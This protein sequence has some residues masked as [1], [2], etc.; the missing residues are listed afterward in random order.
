MKLQLLTLASLAVA[1]VAAPA[2][3]KSS[4]TRAAAERELSADG[5]IKCR[6]MAVTGSFVKKVKLCMTPA[7]W[8]AHY[9]AEKREVNA[10]FGHTNQ[11]STNSVPP[12]TN[13]AGP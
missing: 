9:A 8:R 13:E 5:S 10:L 1:T 11:G 4:P 6:K 12:P 3:A 7:E 2:L